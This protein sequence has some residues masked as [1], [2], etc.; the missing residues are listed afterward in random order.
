MEHTV[1]VPSLAESRKHF[2][3]EFLAFVRQYPEM[4]VCLYVP[5]DDLPLMARGEWSPIV[6]EL[7]A[8]CESGRLSLA[9]MMPRPHLLEY[10]HQVSRDRKS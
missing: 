4:K 2:Y 3:D 10:L 7:L 8:L 6:R 9:G 5:R 1:S